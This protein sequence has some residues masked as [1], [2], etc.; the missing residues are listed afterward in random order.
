MPFTRIDREDPVRLED[1]CHRSSNRCRIGESN[2]SSNDRD[3]QTLSAFATREDNTITV[4]GIMRELLRGR[5]VLV[6]RSVVIENREEG[7]GA[8]VDYDLDIDRR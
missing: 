2:R 4:S 8:V 3:A 5:G 6:A 7:N 1:R